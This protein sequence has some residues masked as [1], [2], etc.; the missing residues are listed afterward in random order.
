MDQQ[1]Y[2]ALYYAGTHPQLTNLLRMWH[3][4][5]EV[6][7][8]FTKQALQ[9]NVDPRTFADVVATALELWKELIH[10]DHDLPDYSDLFLDPTNV[11]KKTIAEINAMVLE[12]GK[13][14]KRLGITEFRET[15][16]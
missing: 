8:E 5:G 4:L 6:H 2:P 1:T 11:D 12:L 9:G 7:R 14:L 16:G 10:Y 13:S 3:E 15:E